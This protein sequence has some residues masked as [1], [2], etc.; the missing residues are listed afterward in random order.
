MP[1]V[2]RNDNSYTD[3]HAGSTIRIVVPLVRSGGFRPD[4]RSSKLQ[5]NTFSIGAV[6]LVGYTT[7]FYAVTGRSGQVHL[8]FVS[9]EQT[10]DGKSAPVAKAAALLPFELPRKSEYVRLVYLVR[11]SQADHNMAIIGCK[12][13]DR[14]NV[15]TERLKEDPDI[16]K[17]STAIFCSWVPAGIAVRRED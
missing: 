9:A 12:N 4:L 10:K 15:Y 5:G 14:L 1:D 6:D 2:V 3:L 13:R 7:S 17:T 8:K 11:V 16:C